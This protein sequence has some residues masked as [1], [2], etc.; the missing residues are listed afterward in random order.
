M[1]K[2]ITSFFIFT[3]LL[4]P[5]TLSSASAREH[6]YIAGS[7]TL[8][9]LLSEVVENLVARQKEGHKSPIV[10]ATGT[11]GGFKMF[12]SG[13]KD[14]YP[15]IIG[16]SRKIKKREEELC[17]KNKVNNV[18]QL[19]VGYDGVVI[20]NHVNAPHYNFTH[21]Q[22]FLAL[23]AR[24]P[25]KGKLISNNIEYWSDIDRSFPAVKIRIY[26]PPSTSGTKDK[27]IE[28]IIAPECKRLKKTLK[29]T[30]ENYQACLAIRHDNRYLA[31]GEND[32]IIVQKLIIDPT[33]LGIFGY[34]FLAQNITVLQGSKVENILPTSQSIFDHS[35]PISRPLYV[36]VKKDR[37]A[38]IS[39][40]QPFLNEFTASDTIGAKGYLTRRGFIPLEDTKLHST[41][42]QVKALLKK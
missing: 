36:Y 4:I 20:A 37:L 26:G 41:Q 1:L 10:E 21:K 29:L 12:C 39:D 31:V 2:R 5:I 35:Y 7:S 8:Y 42:I 24:I 14:R 30:Q 25:E 32:N 15:D 22:L 38:K 34:N 16:A 13:N 6:L 11:G 18:S 19:L 28:L 33:A 9:P 17:Q 27:L 23:A 3:L 40:M